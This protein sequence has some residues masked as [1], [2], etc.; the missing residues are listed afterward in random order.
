MTDHS[1]IFENEEKEAMPKKDV[2]GIPFCITHHCR[3]KQR[4]G[5]GK[6]KAVYYV[7]PVKGCETKAQTVQIE[8]VVPGKPTEC[9]RCK[10]KSIVCER[11]PERSSGAFSILVC[12]GC[13]WASGPQ[14]HPVFAE[15]DILR[16]Q[17]G[18]EETPVANIGDR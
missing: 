13:G 4:S 11:S 6:N 2:D 8:R 17:H 3:M 16:R 1:N 7:C 12:P 15:Q 9:P 18:R 14:P 10:P 5:G